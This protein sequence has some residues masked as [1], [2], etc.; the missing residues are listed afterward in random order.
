MV[1]PVA[2]ADVHLCSDHYCC[3]TGM[4]SVAVEGV[5][6]CTDVMSTCQLSVG[7]IGVQL[8]AV[9]VNDVCL[10]AVWFV[11]QSASID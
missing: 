10:L 7:S 6:V 1:C 5:V 8:S 3:T 11:H 2:V 9:K 4:S